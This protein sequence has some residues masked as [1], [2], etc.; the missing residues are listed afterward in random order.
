MRQSNPPLIDASS[1]YV[2]LRSR[3]AAV[4]FALRLQVPVSDEIRG[5]S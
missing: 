3:A 1:A 4:S 5:D 2:E